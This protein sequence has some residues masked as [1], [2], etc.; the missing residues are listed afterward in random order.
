MCASDVKLAQCC[1]TAATLVGGESKR[2]PYLEQHTHCI[3]LHTHFCNEAVRL[4]LL[5]LPPPWWAD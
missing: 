1:A 4:E 2:R 5:E 3:S